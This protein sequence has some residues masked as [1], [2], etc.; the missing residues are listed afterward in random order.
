[1]VVSALT[2]EEI[3]ND[4]ANQLVSKEKEKSSSELT[5]IAINHRYN[6]EKDHIVKR[7]QGLSGYA[8]MDAKEREN[9]YF[10]YVLARLRGI[11][12]SSF[13]SCATSVG[14]SERI[15]QKKNNRYQMLLLN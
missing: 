15:E 2:Y 7:L 11:Q 10:G 6:L 8:A 9:F 3:E 4:F 5:L 13:Y 1:M 12:E 14:L